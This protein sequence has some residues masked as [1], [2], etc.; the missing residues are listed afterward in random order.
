M[1]PALATAEII[2]FGA[3]KFLRH[4]RQGRYPYCHSLLVLGPE[5]TLIDP[6]ADKV[7]FQSL[8]AAGAVARIFLSHYHEDHRKYLHWFPQAQVWVPQ[9]EVAVFRSL[10]QLQNCMGLEEG[11]YRQYFQEVIVPKFRLHPLS[12][13]QGFSEG[14]EFRLRGVRLVIWHT[15]G[16]TPGHS[17]FYFPDQDIIYLADLDLTPFG[18]WYGDAASDLEALWQ[19]LARLETCPAKTYLTAHGPGIFT[20]AQFQEA[21]RRYR[22]VILQREAALLSHLARPV[23]LEDLV[24]SRL[25]YRPDLKPVFVYDHMERQM[26][27]HHLNWLAKRGLIQSREDGYV[28]A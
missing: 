16:H 15:P 12:A 9:A 3:L 10:E 20:A 25:I 23:T 26:I 11:L 7:R 21:L 24:A 28:A 13:P 22:Q 18:P 19:S 4:H 27:R 2:D 1:A 8:A 6:S 17:C 5:L 14:E